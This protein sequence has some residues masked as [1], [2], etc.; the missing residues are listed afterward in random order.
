MKATRNLWPLGIFTAFT[1]FFAGMA[2]VVVIAATHRDH[3][4]SENYYEQELKYQSRIDSAL[5]TEKIGATIAFDSAKS[6]VC[7]ALPAAQRAQKISGTIQLYRPD[8]PKLDREFPLAPRADGTQ[9]LDVSKLAAGAWRVRASWTAGG[10]DYF[11]EQK[12]TI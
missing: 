10:Q 12:I 9:A 1:L 2:S 6:L 4:V 7:I 8:E 3:L 5:R 11:L